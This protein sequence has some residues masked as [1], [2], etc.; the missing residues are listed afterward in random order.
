MKK[1]KI[2]DYPQLKR[3]SWFYHDDE[4]EEESAL[5][6][7]ERNW[8]YVN[9][10]ELTENENNKI[11]ELALKFNGYEILNALQEIN[12]K[13]FIKMNKNDIKND[14]FDTIEKILNNLNKEIFIKNNIYFGG[15][16]L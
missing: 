16:K 3:I 14:T 8:F 1:L 9:Q 6:I 11:K 12:Y 13:G 4:I 5:R 2:K 10:N 7:Y 15:G